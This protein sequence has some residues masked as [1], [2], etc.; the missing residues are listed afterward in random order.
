MF[1]NIGLGSFLDDFQFGFRTSV[2]HFYPQQ[3]RNGQPANYDIDRF[4]NLCLISQNNNSRFSNDLPE[5]KKANYQK[6]SRSVES[7]KMELMWNEAENWGDE[8]I[9][10]KHEEKMKEILLTTVNIDSNEE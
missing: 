6:S 10:E 9:V 1:Q 4:G 2:E 7:L 3:P 8:Y 5:A